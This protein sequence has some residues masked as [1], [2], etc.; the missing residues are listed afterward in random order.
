MFYCISP[1]KRHKKCL[2]IVLAHSV[3]LE[4]VTENGDSALSMACANA[5]ENEE[6]CLMLL[7]KGINPNAV[8][9]VSLADF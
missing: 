2:D 7:E 4:N 5:E 3:N 6:M 9:K 1:T 8:N